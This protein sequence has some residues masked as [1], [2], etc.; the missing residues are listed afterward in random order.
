MK[1]ISNTAISLDGKI[2]TKHFDHV[3]LGSEQDLIE[4]N[5]IRGLADAIL[6][7]G[8]T[9]RNWPLPLYSQSHTAKKPALNV[10]VTRQAELPFSE[11][12]S[13]ESRIRPLVLSSHPDVVKKCKKEYR[14]YPTTVT[15][16]D[17]LQTLKEFSVQTLLLEC[18]GDLLFQF[19][20][21]GQVDEM[22]VTL[23]PK[24]LGGYG[25][26]TLVDG[27]GFTNRNFPNLHLLK[28]HAIHSEL[29]LHYK[30]LHS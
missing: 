2:A 9:F 15:P 11:N 23:C 21:S 29:Y 30:V 6:V 12:Y 28:S 1:V 25:A 27:K 14:Y 16:A 7:G 10:I 17:I 3:R 20:E 8:N 22:Y 5:R 18:G 13:N 19:L 24:V 26:P 4:M